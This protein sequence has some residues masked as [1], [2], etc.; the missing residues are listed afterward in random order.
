MKTMDELEAE[1]L[2]RYGIVKDEY[3]NWVYGPLPDELKAVL[4]SKERSMLEW[5]ETWN[6]HGDPS[7]MDWLSVA[8]REYSDLCTLMRICLDVGCYERLFGV[9]FCKTHTYTERGSL[10]DPKDVR[11]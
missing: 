2:G 5:A 8:R 1:A 6:A 4:E 9:A 10:R 11:L 7:A 3:G